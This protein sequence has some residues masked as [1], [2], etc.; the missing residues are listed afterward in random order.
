MAG[1]SYSINYNRIQ[2]GLYPGFELK[3]DGAL[4]L[5][6]KEGGHALYLRA[7][8]GGEEKAA[9]GRLHFQVSCSEDMVYYLYAAAFDQDSFYHREQPMLIED[10]LCDSRE[11]QGIKR[12]FMQEAGFSRYTSQKDILLY[13]LQG[14]Y[15]YLVLEVQGEGRFSMRGMRVDRQ[16]DPFMNTFPEIYR[17][18]GS[19]FH[20]YLSVF[21]SIYEDFQEEI[22]ELPRLLDLDICP[23]FLLPVYAS[24]LGLSVGD[25]FLEESVL[26]A[27]VKEAF[28]LNRMKGTRAAL[29]RIA[30]IVLG[31]DVVVLERNVMGA[32]IGK[33]ETAQMNRLYGRT[34][35]DVTILVGRPL[36]EVKKSQ[37]LFLLEQFCPVRARLHVVC[38]KRT[39]IL[40]SYTYLDWNAMVPWQGQGGLD[41]EQEMDGTVCM[42]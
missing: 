30:R 35:Q 40:D 27:L 18:R 1:A 17:E 37:L 5:D 11:S 15:L 26:R 4:I 7:V 31:E 32:Y 13:D 24:W 34:A 25:N 16:G 38:L 2:R 3:E 42:G 23:A 19:F 29:L 12:Q 10:F 33:E 9:W 6:P 36:T 22:D 39:C 28:S 8:D 41:T 14:R 21:S 20:R